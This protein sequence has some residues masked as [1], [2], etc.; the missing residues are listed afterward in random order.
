MPFS[1]AADMDQAGN[2]IGAS[3]RRPQAVNPSRSPR[4]LISTIPA[5]AGTATVPTSRWVKPA[6][7]LEGSVCRAPCG[8]LSACPT[9]L[10]AHGACVMAEGTQSAIRIKGTGSPHDHP[11]N[12]DEPG[13]MLCPAASDFSGIESEPYWRRQFSRQACAVAK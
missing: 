8:A 13:T 9:R 1:R 11:H 2:V 7:C 4:M 10:A 5:M 12:M 3:S 6:E